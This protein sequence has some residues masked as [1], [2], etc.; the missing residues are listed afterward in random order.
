LDAAAVEQGY[1]LIQSEQ[2]FAEHRIIA[3]IYLSNSGFIFVITVLTGG[4]ATSHSVH[5]LNH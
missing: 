4:N 2:P 3:K 1:D 5:Q